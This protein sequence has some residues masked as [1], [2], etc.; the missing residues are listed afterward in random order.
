MARRRRRVAPRRDQTTAALAAHVQASLA[1]T[2]NFRVQ[3]CPG[4]D[5]V[6]WSALWASWKE[7]GGRR[8]LEAAVCVCVCVVCV[9]GGGALW[10]KLGQSI[11]HPHMV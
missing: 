7:V 8:T 2:V 3:P 5:D 1:S 6:N 9:G 11:R 4:P 10:A